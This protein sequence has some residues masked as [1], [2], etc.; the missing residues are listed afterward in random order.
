MVKKG[1]L[2]EEISKLMSEGLV[3]LTK[4]KLKKGP[5]NGEVF[6]VEK[7]IYA[8]AIKRRNAWLSKNENC[9]KQSGKMAVEYRERS[10]KPSRRWSYEDNRGH[11]WDLCKQEC[12]A[13]FTTPQAMIQSVS[14]LALLLICHL[15]RMA[16]PKHLSLPGEDGQSS[17]LC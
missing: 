11:Y 5:L 7:R 14:D 10:Y 4:Q 8:E 6:V 16:F 12:L 13:D 1:F 17:D 3:E 2:E 9:G 15:P